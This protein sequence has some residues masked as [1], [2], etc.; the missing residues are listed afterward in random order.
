MGAK[1]VLA[2]AT[3]VVY[4]RTMELSK[5]IRQDTCVTQIIAVRAVSEMIL[6]RITY[7]KYVNYTEWDFGKSP[8]VNC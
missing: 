2:T 5:L 6:E 3:F 7:R 1:S 8:L 4:A